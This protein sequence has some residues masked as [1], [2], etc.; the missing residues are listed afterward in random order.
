MFKHDF[1]FDPT[2]G[3]SQEQLLAIQPPEPVSGFESFWRETY[4]RTLAV[5][6]NISLELCSFSDD[7][8][9][10][11]EILYD[12][13]EGFR[14]GGWLAVPRSGEVN[15][16]VVIS[17]GYG[18][19]S[20]PA[21]DVQGPPAVILSPCA[22]GFFRSA[23][24]NLPAIT[25]GHVVHGI[26][27]K[28]T[29]LHR[30][31]VADLWAAATALLEYR[32]DLTG[33][34]DFMGGS[35]GGGIGAL[36]MPWENRFRCGF[37][38]VPSFG[39]HPIRT[40]IECVGSGHQ[41]SQAVALKPEL[42]DVLAYYDAAVAARF[43]RQP[44]FLA[45]ALFDPAVPPPGQFAVCNAVT[46]PKVVHIKKAGHFTWEGLPREGR[47]QNEVMTTWFNEI[48]ATGQSSQNA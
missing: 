10:V 30:G 46:S 5:P 13:F 33:K 32:P 18:G 22:R 3:Y 8:R 38:E 20:E 40:T 45:P 42:M 29:Y 36:A 15:R 19:R 43:I 39:H 11:F 2:Y 34:I 31:C 16:G 37:L 1:P 47:A 6:A 41:V 21:L 35:F 4:E 28:E 26:D 25:A 17:H 24:P 48:A 12:S 14:V 9:E 23:R 44:M 27:C 7:K